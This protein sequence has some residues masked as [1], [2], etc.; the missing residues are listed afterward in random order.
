MMYV[1]TFSI[2]INNQKYNNEKKKEG[3]CP[4]ILE[5]VDMVEEKKCRSKILVSRGTSIILPMASSVIINSKKPLL[6]IFV[7]I[8][9]ASI[10]SKDLEVEYNLICYVVDMTELII[11]IWILVN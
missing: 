1:P 3:S 2:L 9:N 5:Q 4:G 6:N 11:R 10:S 7:F 8:P